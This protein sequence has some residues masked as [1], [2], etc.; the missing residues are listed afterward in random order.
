MLEAVPGR[1]CGTCGMCCK[2]PV[3]VEL[4]KPRNQWCVNAEIGKGCKIYDTR[5]GECRAFMCEWIINAQLSDA[6]KPERCKFIIASQGN[7]LNVFVDLATPNAWRAPEFYPTLKKVAT[8][9][10]KKNQIMIVLIGE[11]RIVVLPDRDE[12]LGNIGNRHIIQ[13]GTRS[14]LGKMEY[15]IRTVPVE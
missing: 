10:V 12:D 8:E 13:L 15:L 4:N 6:W 9:L 1:A 3:V 2:L 14:L 5:P 11:R 7:E